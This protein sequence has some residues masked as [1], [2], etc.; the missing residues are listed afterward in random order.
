MIV[1]ITN[2]RLKNIFTFPLFAKYAAS[3]RMQIKAAKGVLHSGFY[4]R[5]PMDFLTM[6]CWDSKE[7]MLLY[8]NN[9]AH[10]EAMKRFPDIANMLD[11]TITTWEAEEV[12]T[13]KEALRRVDANKDYDYFST[14]AY[15][16][17]EHYKKGLRHCKRSEA[18]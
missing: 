5:F 18:I 6:S 9:G 14:A 15:K 2:L 4:Y 3:S 1:V 11:S 7:N 8:S 12:P 17:T 13:W 10:L 16:L